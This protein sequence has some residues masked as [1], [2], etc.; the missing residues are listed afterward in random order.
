MRFKGSRNRGLT[1]NAVFASIV[2]SIVAM[3]MLGACG[4]DEAEVADTPTSEPIVEPTATPQPEPTVKPTEE[5]TQ[6]PTAEPTAA[7]TEEP[8][9]ERTEP[10][11]LF[12]KDVRDID[13]WINSEPTSIAELTSQGKVVLVDFWTYTCVNCLRTLPFLR[14]WQEKYVDNGLVILGVHAPE[15]EF[16]KELEN[17]QR[18]V[19]DEGIKWPVALDN[20]MSTWRS[21]N[22]RY[23]PAKYLVGVDGEIHYSHFGE[24]AYR[25]TEL[26]IRK[27]LT[28]AGYDVSAIPVGDVE[29]TERDD[30]ARSVTRELY[31]GYDRSYSVYGLYA[32]QDEYYVE[33][34][35]EIEYEDR[36]AEHDS[37]PPQKFVLNGLWRNEQEAIVHARETMD[38]SDYIAFRFQGRSAN[39]VIDPPEPGE[40]KVYVDLDDRPLAE[41]EAGDDIQFDDEGRSYFNV[42]E[43]RLYKIVETPEYVEQTLKLSSNSPNFAIFAFTFGIYDGGY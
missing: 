20:E 5:P 37:Y 43:S 11:E 40:F 25:E 13:A 30:A 28:N 1:F 17:V 22:N 7:P 24:G 21:F 15:F 32:A 14:E 31:G 38:L 27:V 19:D 16:E 41:N 2:V 6:E 23:W 42:E 29:N 39:V 35:R 34:D 10:A 12:D 4:S 3:L 33:P 8:V 9:A 26:E 18:A 36:Y